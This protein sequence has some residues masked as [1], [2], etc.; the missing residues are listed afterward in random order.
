VS[1]TNPTKETHMQTK[2]NPSAVKNRQ[3]AEIAW[4][5]AMK[6][7]QRGDLLAYADLI[8]AHAYYIRAAVN[9]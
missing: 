7:R 8:E 3:Y 1:K 4:N 6:A 2:T 9:A 5:E